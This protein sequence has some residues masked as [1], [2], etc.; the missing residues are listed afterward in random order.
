MTVRMGANGM[1]MPEKVEEKKEEVLQEILE[2][3]PNK[4]KK[5]ADTDELS[6]EW[7]AEEVKT[8]EEL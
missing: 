8:D 4:K 2:V 1:P 7:D 5:K 3:N 6:S